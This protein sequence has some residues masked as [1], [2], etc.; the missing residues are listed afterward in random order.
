MDDVPPPR[1]FLSDPIR[2]PRWLSICL[3]VFRFA[4]GWL[5]GAYLLCRGLAGLVF[6]PFQ[7]QWA[8]PLSLS[9]IVWLW[10][11]HSRIERRLIPPSSQYPAV[12]TLITALCLGL[13][14]STILMWV[15]SY[16]QGWCYSKADSNGMS[17][18]CLSGNGRIAYSVDYY[19]APWKPSI[20][21]QAW[22]LAAGGGNDGFLFLTINSRIFNEPSFLGFG[23]CECHHAQAVSFA[24]TFDLNGPFITTVEHQKAW[25]IPYWFP[26]ALT[27][28]PPLW[29]FIL[30]RRRY[31][32]WQRQQHG[33][34]L[35]CGYDLRATPERCPECGLVVNTGNPK[36][37]SLASPPT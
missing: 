10:V 11:V 21:Q 37:S 9:G 5:I 18:R 32:R 31:R 7:W 15:A 36:L 6:P 17:R 29:W 20:E 2:L 16:D 33:L 27:V 1:S 25:W 22:A 35:Q 8:G 23:R 19:D 14:F 28:V 30:F 3:R 26:V 34:C 24:V 13:C 4:I 12:G